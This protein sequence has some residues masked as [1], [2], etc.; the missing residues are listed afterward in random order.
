MHRKKQSAYKSSLS[1][2]LKV[3]QLPI[4]IVA[5]GMVLSIGSFLM[6][7]RYDVQEAKEDFVSLSDQVYRNFEA[8]INRHRR[9]TASLARV[10]SEL[11][12]YTEA[13]FS[14]VAE[15]FIANSYFTHINIY[16]ISEPKSDHVLNANSSPHVERYFF[17]NLYEKRDASI[18]ETSELISAIEKSAKLKMDFVSKPYEVMTAEGTKNYIVISV[19]LS[20][21]KVKG[22][23]LVFVLDIQKLL[24]TSLKKN[25]STLST[26][27]FSLDR[28]ENGRVGINGANKNIIYENFSSNSGKEFILA[29]QRQGF[30]ITLSKKEYYFNDYL[31]EVEFIPSIENYGNEIGLFPLITFFSVVTITV[32]FSFIV[33]RI[34]GEQVRTQQIVVEQTKNLQ[35]YTKRLEESNRELDDFVYVVSHDLKEPLRGLYS[36]SYF[37]QEDY[38]DKLDDVGNDKLETLKKLSLRMEELIN[39]L[40]YYSRLGRSEEAFKQTDLNITLENTLE[41]LNPVIEKENADIKIENTLPTILCD[42]AHIGDIFRNLIVNGLK[43]NDSDHKKILIGCNVGYKE[44]PNT[45]VF[46]VSDNGIGIDPK[47]HDTIFKMFKRLHGKNEYGGGTGSGLTIVK[48]IIDRHNGKIWVESNEEGGSTFYFILGDYE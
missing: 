31:W 13:E 28:P 20:E 35:E 48:K 15:A 14:D 19:P 18:F 30:D 11:T 6:A 5:I 3:Y 42:R 1:E 45:N 38:A 33:F 22:L 4:L 36:Y 26:R 8:E 27:V 10:L 16:Q 23:F 39:T 24:D 43:Y 7:L 44:S 29:T 12:S 37:L 17:K 25:N 40:L 41:L 21:K 32:L 2:I 46:Y 47:H 34:K 9:Q